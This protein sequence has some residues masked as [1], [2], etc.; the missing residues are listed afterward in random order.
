[1]DFPGL[2]HPDNIPNAVPR[3]EDKSVLGNPPFYEVYGKTYHVL[4]EAEKFEQS[5]V[6]SWYG[7]QFHGRK[8]SNGEIYDMFKMTAAHKRLPLPSYVKVT[9]LSN[10]HSVV[11]RV[12][13]RGPFR[14]NRIIDLSYAAAVKLG[15]AK[16][17]TA[18]VRIQTINTDP[19]Q[20]NPLTSKAGHDPQTHQRLAQANTQ[21]AAYPRVQQ[22]KPANTSTQQH[23]I[24][25][26]AFANISNAKRLRNKI[27]KTSLPEPQIYLSKGDE[28]NLYRLRIGPLQSLTEQKMIA[29]ELSRMGVEHRLVKMST[30]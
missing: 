23:Y 8:T 11:V 1:M 13:D 16:S 17:G 29:L 12:N 10:G 19:N 7:R 30:N 15:M 3:T 21:Q 27:K 20:S 9:N 18:P 6:A 22:A 24:Q 14:D 28:K 5:G 2:D 25:L 4:K 26:G